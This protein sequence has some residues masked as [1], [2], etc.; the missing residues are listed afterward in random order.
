MGN[1][2]TKLAEDLFFNQQLLQLYM[3]SN[4]TFI[5]DYKTAFKGIGLDFYQNRLYSQDDSIRQINWYLFAKLRELYVKEYIE[6]RN[7]YNVIC[8]DISKSMF[9][10][11]K[12]PYKMEQALG[13]A[14]LLL[15]SSLKVGDNTCFLLFS[16]DV[17]LFFPFKK[18][19][20]TFFQIFS[21]LKNLTVD[22]EASF[23]CHK[24]FEKL[25]NILKKRAHIFLVSDFIFRLDEKLLQSLTQKHN[26]T[27]ITIIDDEER[28]IDSLLKN[29]S[30]YEY[31]SLLK[32]ETYY[33]TYY[34]NSS[35]LKK[36]NID[37]VPIS[38]INNPLSTL[39]NF[40]RSKRTVN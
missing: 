6:D 5:G 23:E 18:N 16:D 14:L 10:K 28:R 30:S 25:F 12:K 20:N 1:M 2:K 9:I 39:Q 37:V 19:F 38:S 13:V 7:R 8:L 34:K 24:I 29:R 31:S 32:Q 22:L 40:L 35:I 17:K 4:K 26:L 3:I 36:Y 11:I 27:A 21:C 15:Y 33:E